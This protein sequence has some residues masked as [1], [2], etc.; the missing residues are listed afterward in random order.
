MADEP[1]RLSEI[2][3]SSET[4]AESPVE[5]K[6]PPPEETKKAQKKPKLRLPKLGK[7]K[8]EKSS[9][10]KADKQPPPEPI[11]AEELVNDID[12]DIT[13]LD[14]TTQESL[15][16]NLTKQ[17]NSVGQNQIKISITKQQFVV[18]FG[19]LV[20]LA[21]AIPLSQLVQ[22]IPQD[23]NLPAIF[24]RGDNAVTNPQASE[25]ASIVTE[26]SSSGLL[27]RIKTPDKQAAIVQNFVSRLG[28]NQYQ[29]IDIIQEPVSEEEIT[30]VT[31][32]TTADEF[33]KINSILTEY[34][35][36]ASSTVLSED[37]SFSAVLIVP[38]PAE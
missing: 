6:S 3:K 28:S 22:T 10:A 5:E 12:K 4:E 2:E 19:L 36:S 29:F 14:K 18:Y 1:K 37:S 32:E 34:E 9:E 7:K 17:I 13:I 33:D 16:E 27:I 35:L 31:K 24:N 26:S 38:I 8:A 11:S 30:V 21:W 20:I 23:F 15:D 25:S